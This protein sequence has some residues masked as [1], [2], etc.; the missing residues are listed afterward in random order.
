MMDALVTGGVR[1]LAFAGGDPTLRR[2]LGE[3]V[4]YA[5]GV[6]LRTEVQTNAQLSN[7]RVWSALRQADRVCLSLD[8][9][10]SAIHDQMRL[11][12]GNFAKV[13]N[14]AERLNT[15]GIPFTIR[16]VITRE[17][18]T[19]VPEIATT[20]SRFSA[21][22]T[23]TLLEFTP[24]NE[25][26]HN[27]AAYKLTEE[28]FDHVIKLVRQR[29]TGQAELDVF[30]NSDK[31]DAYMQV[32]AAARVYGTTRET[33]YETGTP[34]MVASVLSDHLSDIA[35]MLPLDPRKHVRRYSRKVEQRNPL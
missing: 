20:V 16:T 12:R 33:I 22:E 14:L 10:N 6:G 5:R 29:D 27:Q 11:Q 3:L 2:D 32:T 30:R 18:F 26:F 1:V 24:V 23:W 28:E 35:S 21:C 15:A 13:V 17:N 9:P 25:G 34:R 4:E 31:V 8:G 19:H 7:E